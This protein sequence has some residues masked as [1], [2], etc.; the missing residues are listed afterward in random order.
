MLVGTRC[1]DAKFDSINFDGIQCLVYVTGF[2]GAEFADY[3]TRQL[4]KLDRRDDFTNKDLTV[5]SSSRTRKMQECWRTPQ[6]P[7]FPSTTSAGGEKEDLQAGTRT[8]E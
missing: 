5:N 7:A 2:Q 4:R 1:S 3:R 8:K 6:T